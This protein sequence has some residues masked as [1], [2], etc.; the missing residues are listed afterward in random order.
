[1]SAHINR[2]LPLTLAAIGIV[3][4]D[5][6]HRKADHDKVDQ[7]L[8]TVTQPLLTEAAARFDRDVVTIAT[9]YGIGYTA[10]FQQVQAWRERAW[11]YAELLSEAP[12]AQAR[13][14]VVQEIE[15][16]AAVEAQSI[17][18]T[19]S[20]LPPVTTTS[21]RDAYCATHNATAPPMAYAFG[22]PSAY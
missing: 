7:F 6:Q 20:Y 21:A 9:P 12:T 10:L 13:A 8:N 1:M 14:L 16:S 5:G 19:Y 11:R 4:A 15:T 3:T 22:S 2:D 18:A 17:V